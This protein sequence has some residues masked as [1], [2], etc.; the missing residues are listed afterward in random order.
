VP[1]MTRMKAKQVRSMMAV[2]GWQ[3]GYSNR[4]V[5]L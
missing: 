4:I 1:A 5:G 2:S 3:R